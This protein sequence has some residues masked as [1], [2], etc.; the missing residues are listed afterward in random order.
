M[1]KILVWIAVVMLGIYVVK[2]RYL[3]STTHQPFI[4]GCLASGS[5]SPEQCRC[6][7]D[8]LHRIY[9][10]KEMQAIMAGNYNTSLPKEQVEQ[11]IFQGSRACQTAD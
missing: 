5:A 9:S 10:D 1:A 7:A 11:R 2:T 6:L 3:T 4:D 8:Y